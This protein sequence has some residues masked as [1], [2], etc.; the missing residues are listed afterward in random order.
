MPL[1]PPPQSPRLL[2]PPRAANVGLGLSLPVRTPPHPSWE[3]EAGSFRLLRPLPA[4]TQT[5]LA[6]SQP[7]APGVTA[8]QEQAYLS[9]TAEVV[10]HLGGGPEQA[11][12]RGGRPQLQDPAEVRGVGGGAAG[13][14]GWW[15]MR[16]LALGGQAELLGSPGEGRTGAGGGTQCCPSHLPRPGCTPQPGTGPWAGVA[17]SYPWRLAQCRPGLLQ[18]PWVPCPAAAGGMGRGGGWS[19]LGS[20]TPRPGHPGVST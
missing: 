7:P 17:V 1:G 18:L 11:G 9:D 19:V 15:R 4:P 14:R 5:P 3:K 13:S 8:N 6:S 10:L 16:F 20:A 12:G 2:L